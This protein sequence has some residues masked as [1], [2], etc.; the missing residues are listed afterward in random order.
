MM[1]EQGARSQQHSSMEEWEAVVHAAA[2]QYPY[3]RT[4]NLA[5]RLAISPARA[6]R[7]WRLARAA[8]V[9]FA[10][11]VLALLAVTPV[12]AW[13]WEIIQ[14][15]VVRILPAPM[16]V[17]TAMATA[18]PLASLVDL[19]GRT[20][21]VEAQAQLPFALAAP[22]DPADIGP[23]DYVFVQDLDGPAA[24]LVWG[25]P[26]EPSRV[27]M[28]LTLLTSPAIAYKTAPEQVVPVTVHG[29]PAL[30]TTGPYLVQVGDGELALRWLVKGHVLIW[31]DGSVTYRLETDVSQARAIQI[32][33]SVRELPLLES[34]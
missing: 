29:E 24:V 22:T 27:R 12:R 33:E 21:L 34:D 16:P 31:T 7:G 25:D 5:G 15:G 4:P 10:L 2:Q 13:V 26:E 23:P 17:P 9:A 30:W 19:G 3:P 8:A 28:S 18:T 6:R 1:D 20:T 32:A 11:V 14:I